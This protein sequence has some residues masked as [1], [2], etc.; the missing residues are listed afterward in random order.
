M[1]QQLSI[2]PETLIT[3]STEQK[4]LDQRVFCR[5]REQEGDEKQGGK[6]NTKRRFCNSVAQMKREEICR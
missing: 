3:G 1:R 5:R 6:G 2:P 4:H